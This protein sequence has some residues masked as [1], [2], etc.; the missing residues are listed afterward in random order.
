M[1]QVEDEEYTLDVGG[2]MYTALEQLV[3]S[4]IFTVVKA[5]I[6]EV[7]TFVAT[8]DEVQLYDTYELQLPLAGDSVLTFQSATIRSC[9]ATLLLS[10]QKKHI[11]KLMQAEFSCTADLGE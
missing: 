9:A 4:G 8:G 5:S 1:H 10:H 11:R 6:D 3:L 2:R 7:R